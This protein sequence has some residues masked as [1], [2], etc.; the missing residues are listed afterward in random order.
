[1]KK[2]RFFTCISYKNAVS[3][4]DLKK[5]LD[6]WEFIKGYVI[7]PLHTDSK[8]EHWHIV[9]RCFEET[10][11]SN[12]R[13][14][15]RNDLPP[16]VIHNY[17]FEQ[18]LK[19]DNMV[20]YLIHKNSVV[21]I[22]YNADDCYI[23]NFPQAE[24]ILKGVSVDEYFSKLM[25]LIRDGDFINFWEFFHFVEFNDELSINFKRWCL[26]KQIFIKNLLASRRYCDVDIKKRK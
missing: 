8:N 4:A 6:N 23:C 14:H 21:K 3:Y 16:K 13:S 25:D 22:K 1:M 11:L 19:M 2:T 12:L 10:T 24:R 9:I 5:Y 20:D 18:V 7:S 15:C 17:Y 26:G